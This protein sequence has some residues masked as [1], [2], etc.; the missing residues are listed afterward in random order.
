MLFRFT[1]TFNGLHVI[2]EAENREEALE[3][4][5]LAR[6]PYK[7]TPGMTE[8]GMKTLQEDFNNWLGMEK[9]VLSEDWL[10]DEL[11]KYGDFV[12]RKTLKERDLSLFDLLAHSQE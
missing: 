3:L 7:M 1:S 5:A 8:E 9:K 6:C 11:E 2:V 12:S 10:C 4:L